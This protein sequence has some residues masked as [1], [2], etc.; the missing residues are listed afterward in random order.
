MSLP[1]EHQYLMPCLQL[2]WQ[3]GLRRESWCNKIVCKLYIELEIVLVRV[4]VGEE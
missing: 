2:V 1:Q 3:W 4:L